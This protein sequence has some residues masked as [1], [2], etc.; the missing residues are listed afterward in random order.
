[1]REDEEPLLTRLWRLVRSDIPGVRQGLIGTAL[2]ALGALVWA[3]FFASPQDLS[4]DLNA[5]QECSQGRLIYI[6]KKFDDPTTPLTNGADMLTICDTESLQ[7]T[8][9]ELPH[10]LSIRFPGCL[11]WRGKE[12]GGLIMVRKS[13]AVCA[14]PDGKGFVCDGANAR[15]SS[16]T[17]AIGDSVDPV[18]PCSDD[19]LRRFGF[20]P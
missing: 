20:R 16:G 6:R 18:K 11:V 1:M 15:H 4:L 14:L 13:D 7:T 12:S 10:D 8:R 19:T 2:V 5:V 3:W 17:S 9:P